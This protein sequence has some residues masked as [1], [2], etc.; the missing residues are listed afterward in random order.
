MGDHGRV[1]TITSAEHF[2]KEIQKDRVIVDFFATW[3]APCR[4]ISPLVVQMSTEHENVTFLKV[5]VDQIS[6]PTKEDVKDKIEFFLDR[7][8]I[9]ISDIDALVLGLNGDIITDEYY[10]YVMNELFPGTGVISFKNLVGEYPTSSAFACWLSAKILLDNKMPASSIY[11]S[12]N[13]EIKTILIYN[14][15]EGIQHGFILLRK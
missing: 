15:Y 1:T 9:P 7:N 3:C 10:H 14:H 4:R 5:D 12:V 6:F 11:K 13:S 8:N 2:N